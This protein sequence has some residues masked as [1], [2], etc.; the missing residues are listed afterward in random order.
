MYDTLVQYA[1]YLFPCSLPGMKMVSFDSDYSVGGDASP[2]FFLDV[3]D[4]YI[5]GPR[6]THPHFVA[7]EM[8]LVRMLLI[9]CFVCVKGSCIYFKY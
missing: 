2:F 5:F 9:M 7:R 6:I 3:S 4:V 8:I 1:A